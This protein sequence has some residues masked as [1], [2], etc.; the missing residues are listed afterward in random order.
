MAKGANTIGTN[1]KKTKSKQRTSIGHSSNTRYTKKHQKQNG[2]KS[3]K[4]QGK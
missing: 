2:K 1:Q 3:Y 4:G